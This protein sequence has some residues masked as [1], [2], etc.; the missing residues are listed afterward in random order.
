VATK[1]TTNANAGK[2]LNKVRNQVLTATQRSEIARTAA[3]ARWNT[4]RRKTGADRE[5]RLPNAGEAKARQLG[6]TAKE[7][8]NLK[9]TLRRKVSARERRLRTLEERTATRFRILRA[10]VA[11]EL[12]RCYDYGDYRQI[13][14]YAA[15]ELA[16]V[17][18]ELD[19]LET[20]IGKLRTTR[21]STIVRNPTRTRKKS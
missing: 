5:S 4:P 19:R 13:M 17:A 1:P 8:F 14:D 2:N 3:K 16:P 20:A 9:R 11:H 6:E 10:G 18:K 21:R 12:G 15:A 7:V